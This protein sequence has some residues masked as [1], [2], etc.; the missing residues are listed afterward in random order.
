M[1]ISKGESSCK[2]VV[3]ISTR[4]RLKKG[5]RNATAD[6]SQICVKLPAHSEQTR[7]TLNFGACVIQHPPY[8]VFRLSS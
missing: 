7:H 4:C 3:K 2:N 5:R 8:Y 6:K 1:P